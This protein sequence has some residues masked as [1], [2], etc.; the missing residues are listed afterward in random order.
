[1]EASDRTPLRRPGAG[2][3]E[4]LYRQL[5]ADLASRIGSGELAPGSPVPSERLIAKQYGVSSITARRALL[6]L[7]REGLIYGHQGIGRF[8][9]D[10]A[11]ERHVTLLLAGFDAARWRS[12]AG[13]MG[14]VVGGATEVTWR[15]DCAFHVVRVDRPLETSLLRRLLEG[16]GSR[17]LL[18]R[19]AGDVQPE[20]VDLLEAAH[21]PYVYIRR[22]LPDRAMNCVIPADDAGMRLAVAHLAGL[23]H[24]RIG[25]VSAMPA[26]GLVRER[27]R[28]YRAALAAHGLPTT[29]RYERLADHWDAAAGYRCATE[30]FEEPSRPTAVVVDVDLAPGVYEAAAEHGLRIPDDVAVVGYDEVPEAQALS[31]RLTCVRTSHYDTARAAAELL[32]E[33]MAGAE[34]PPRRLYI[35]P[36]LEVR[37]SCG[38]A[39]WAG[40]GA[41]GALRPP[42][43]SGPGGWTTE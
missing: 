1:M 39:A 13:A 4:P 2:P 15:H 14:E 19:V 42:A 41:L 17:G 43:T 10:V 30:L 40:G 31:P 24:R 23:G 36:L 25:L 5:R 7:T 34:P 16:T 37:E 21:H 22:H 26:L 28:G 32:L 33:L 9:A 6:E 20:H 18:V 35:E 3:V 8:V 29:G 12:S 11:R 27:L 38:G